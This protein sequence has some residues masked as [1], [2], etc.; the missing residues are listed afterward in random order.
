MRLLLWSWRLKSCNDSLRI[1][2]KITSNCLLPSESFNALALQVESIKHYLIKDILELVLRQRRTLHVLD[3][4][5]LLS[6]TLA[7]LL[8][9]WAHLLLRK[10][11]A[12]AW[13]IAQIGLGTNDQAR[14]TWAVVVDLREPLLAH[15]LE[16]GWGGDGEADE[17][18]VG[19][20]VG[21][22]AQT[23][24][25]LLSGGI[26]E[27][28]SIWLITDPKDCVSLIIA[29]SQPSKERV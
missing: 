24:V 6:H 4:T 25:I 12:H 3:S 17:E 8:T 20:W 1:I 7:V 26:K 21:E 13:V 23:I 27:A 18:D 9:D 16:G 29:K 19:L 15:V 22:W 28:K 14:N 2:S 5:Q 11:L 10:L